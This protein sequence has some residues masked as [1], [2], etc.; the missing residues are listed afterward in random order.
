MFTRQDG[1]YERLG[2]HSTRVPE[3]S[4]ACSRVLG[5]P[6]CSSEPQHSP[7]GDAAA[8]TIP[9][10][11]LPG[12]SPDRP[13]GPLQGAAER[14]AGRVVLPR[15]PFALTDVGALTWIPAG[16]GPSDPVELAQP[17]LLPRQVFEG[18]LG[19]PVPVS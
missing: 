9:D 2:A 3:A 5:V 6:A 12:T 8:V 17:V 15:Y 13:A 11:I 18:M 1:G 4:S 19:D 14:P 16:S 10:G 7:T